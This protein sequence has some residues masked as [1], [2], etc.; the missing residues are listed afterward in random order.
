M[1]PA[2]NNVQKA[3]VS[4]C[5]PVYNGEKFLSEAIESILAQTFTDFELLLSDD[6]ST[7]SSYEIMEKYARRD[8]RVKA[9]RNEKNRGLFGNWNLTM[10]RA[11]GKYI[12]P[13]AQ[14]DFCKPTFLQL[15]VD[16]L[17]H[18]P[19]VALVAAAREVFQD[20]KVLLVKPDP[21][22][23]PCDQLFTGKDITSKYLFHFENVVGFPPA[24]MFR[25]EHLGSGF[26]SRYHHCGD[27]ELWLRIL[28]KGDFYY[29]AEPQVSFRYHEKNQSITN[30]VELR[31]MSDLL[32]LKD[33]YR[34]VVEEQDRARFDHAIADQLANFIPLG[35]E[36]FG[37]D[38][39]ATIG[40]SFL[41]DPRI[42]FD[43][44]VS[45]SE[46]IVFMKSE[47]HTSQATLDSYRQE[48]DQLNSQVSL[49]KDESASL[50]MRVDHLEEENQSLRH[51]V[52]AIE[53]STSWRI[54]K[55]IRHLVQRFARS[56]H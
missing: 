27:A 47:L 49:L 17:D 54:T 45:L 26:D 11:G 31:Y 5:L 34:E 41:A 42:A 4:V 53:E 33:T 21:E 30:F 2:Q 10:G 52:H 50:R 39:A 38:H 28:A 13:F 14:D 18:H 40:T 23:Y 15:L 56:P 16:A 19:N 51:S 55:P 20:G 8:K 32:L 9:W 36:T 25:R 37:I 22:K 1:S 7:D 24:V 3:R 46:R 12:K 29:V 43:V 35:R 6:C 44:V 48:I